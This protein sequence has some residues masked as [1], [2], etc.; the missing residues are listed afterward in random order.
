MSEVNEH[1]KLVLTS[2]NPDWYPNSP[3]YAQ[4]ESEM[5]NWK[6]E[7]RTRKKP[8]REV[9]SVKAP[10]PLRPKTNTPTPNTE[11]MNDWPKTTTPITKP[12]VRI[13]D[14]TSLLLEKVKIRSFSSTRQNGVSP[15]AL[16]ENGI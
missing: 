2:K 4:Q 13:D 11:C 14:F 8:Y 1:I 9:L 15:E 16:A 5:K 10:L 12:Q 6:G 7:I 3:I